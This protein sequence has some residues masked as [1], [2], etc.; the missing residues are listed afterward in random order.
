MQN[1]L[2]GLKG[3]ECQIDDVLVLAY[4]Y[5]QHDQRSEAVLKRIEDYGI[6]L[7]IKKCEFAKEKIQLLGY[8]FGEDGIEESPSK[9]EAIS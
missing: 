1:L 7:N 5:E 8:L 2:A 4:T 6:T 3:V 9:V